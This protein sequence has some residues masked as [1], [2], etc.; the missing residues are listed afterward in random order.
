MGDAALMNLYTLQKW[1]S[2]GLINNTAT[3]RKLLEALLESDE[4]ELAQEVCDLLR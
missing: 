1:R 3:Y 4:N 2:A